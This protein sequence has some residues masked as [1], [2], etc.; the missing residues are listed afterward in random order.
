MTARAILKAKPG[1][2]VGLGGGL[3]L[4]CDSRNESRYFELRKHV[5]GK[6]YSWGCGSVESLTMAGCNKALTAARER[7]EQ[8]TA[9]I[10]A[11]VDPA[12]IG[13]GADSSSAMTSRSPLRDVAKEYV[14]SKGEE[15]T[16]ERHRNTWLNPLE[17]HADWLM[18]SA[19]G[20][21]SLDDVISALKPHWLDKTDT[22]SRMRAKLSRVFSF[23]VVLKL[24]HDD[25]AD[26]KLLSHVFP[27]QSKVAPVVHRKSMDYQDCPKLVRDLQELD[28]AS[29]KALLWTLYSAT[30]SKEG[31]GA[32]WSEIDLPGRVWRLEASRIKQRRNFVI[33][34]TA[35][36][37]GLLDWAAKLGEFGVVF[38][39]S[40]KMLSDVA[41]SKTLKRLTFSENTVHGLRSSFRVW[42]QETDVDEFVAEHCLNHL[43]GSDVR[44]A[45]AR[46]D[47]LEER[48]RV[49]TDWAEF[50]ASGTS[51]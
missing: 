37:E 42:C 9:S 51:N 28:T 6:N 31:R 13:R 14:S 49:M 32:E 10:K 24:R 50:L 2:K 27:A 29:A 40:E 47:M 4:I 11:G 43:V 21:I 23:A 8:I 44:R 36:M 1:S 39:T 45:Y 35:P 48:M 30:R 20:D 12:S 33:P 22:A 46:S 7:A 19:I 3:R 17:Q 5:R 34:I 25:P 26:W 16:S 41:V 38:S 15:W 18:G